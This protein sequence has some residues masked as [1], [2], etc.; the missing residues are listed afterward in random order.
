MRRSHLSFN[1]N[2]PY[3]LNDVIDAIHRHFRNGETINFTKLGEYVLRRSKVA[4]LIFPSI[5]GQQPDNL[6]ET[7]KTHIYP[8]PSEI[9]NAIEEIH[10]LD[11]TVIHDITEYIRDITR[12]GTPLFI[13]L[14]TDLKRG[15][16][17]FACRHSKSNRCKA[18][19]K[20][21]LIGTQY[22]LLQS[23]LM[24]NHPI[25]DLVEGHHRNQML[26]NREIYF[27]RNC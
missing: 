1:A 7:K 4:P 21:R 13:A 25:T 17:S 18:Y 11:N 2:C 6:F 24:H 10:H 27:I 20:I 5:F 16:F 26:R 19:L 22:F 3:N 23:F 14:R 12:I 9:I 8:T 15:N